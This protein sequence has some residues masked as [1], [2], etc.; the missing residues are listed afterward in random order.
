M[1]L[2]KGSVQKTG[3]HSMLSRFWQVAGITATAAMLAA[4]PSRAQSSAVSAQEIS[5]LREQVL[6]SSVRFSSWKERLQRLISGRPL[7]R[8]Q[9]H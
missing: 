5:D 6:R 1:R 3:E 7:D 9:S 2:F 4:G 8:R